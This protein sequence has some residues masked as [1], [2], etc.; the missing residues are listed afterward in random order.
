MK[1]KCEAWQIKCKYCNCFFEYTNFK[2]NSIEYKCLYCNRNNQ[3]K[4]D[5]KL[6][7]RCLNF[8][9]MIIISLFYC[10][11]PYE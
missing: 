11:N 9:T 1:T 3:H 10:C 7:E 6:K 8:L 4:F 2:D 5:E